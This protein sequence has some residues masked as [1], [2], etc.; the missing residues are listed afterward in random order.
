MDKNACLIKCK[1]EAEQIKGQCYRYS[2]VNSA[3]IIIGVN[4]LIARTVLYIIRIASLY[5]ACMLI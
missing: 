1:T 3:I 2:C 5:S 4:C